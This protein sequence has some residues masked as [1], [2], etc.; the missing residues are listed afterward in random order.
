M[1]TRVVHDRL[2]GQFIELVGNKVPLRLDV[3]GWKALDEAAEELGIP[4]R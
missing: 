1:I 3:A 2:I 4:H